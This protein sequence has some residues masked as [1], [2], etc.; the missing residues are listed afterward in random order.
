MTSLDG[1][2]PCSASVVLVHLSDLH[3]RVGEHG[4][5]ERNSFLR[6]QIAA[7]LPGV[8]DRVSAQGPRVVVVTG[9]IAFSGKAAE[10]DIARSWLHQLCDI[11]GTDPTRMLVVPGNHDV[12]RDE[13]TEP[14]LG[15]R[16]QIRTSD[17]YLVDHLIDQLLNTPEVALSPLQAYNAFAS[18]SNCQ[19]GRELHWDAPL[20]LDHGY[21]VRFRG[22]TTV[23]NSG[24]TDDP[25]GSLAVHENQLLL[26][27]GPGQFTVLLAHH[28]PQF[29]L[30]HPATTP[31]K[32]GASIALYGHTHSPDIEV[33][34]KCVIVTA[35]A[36]Q[37]DEGA[38][39]NPTYN[40]L[41]LKVLEQRDSDAILEARIWRRRYAGH[42]GFVDDSPDHEGLVR[43]VPIARAVPPSAPD[44]EVDSD[45]PSSD[46]EVE[47]EGDVDEREPLA[48][49]GG[50]P[51]PERVLMLE[52]SAM[53]D[54]E[55]A[56]LLE[57]V[58]FSEPTLSALPMH[59]YI[60]A[61]ARRLV[62]M[63]LYERVSDAMARS[64]TDEDHSN[65]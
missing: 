61:L 54:G 52:L 13:I 11:V 24:P 1:P 58:G 2:I 47:E 18:G 29:W 35:G 48:D 20:P 44:A 38:D 32:A 15:H 37:P 46:L 45:E 23:L 50:G 21:E 27:H 31:Q 33:A 12:D 30:K 5:E 40:V 8:L 36:T 49:P 7:D 17:P 39:W 43:Q 16:E 28:D 55:R 19:I 62:E 34:E 41:E 4:R 25:R 63:G 22:I 59:Q 56:A 51:Q 64:R 65:G 42:L 57:Y 9:D 6:E 26:R 60:P 10:Y 3:C 53:G 14:Q